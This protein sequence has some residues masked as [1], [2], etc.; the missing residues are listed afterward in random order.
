MST[1]SSARRA[2]FI[3]AAVLAALVRLVVLQ[4]SARAAGTQVLHLSARGH[5]VLRFNVNHLTA[6]P[7]RIELVMANP[8]D[9]GMSHGIAISGNGVDKDGK[10][11]SPG[12]ASTVTVT[13]RRR[14]Y[15]YYCPVPGHRAA[16]MKGTS[17]FAERHEATGT[18]GQPQAVADRAARAASQWS[19]SPGSVAA[20]VRAFRCRGRVSE[21]HE[22]RRS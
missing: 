4:A 6:H 19:A 1:A 13:L 7:G 21:S 20:A 17:P 11:V 22:V 18:A 8:G 12:R 10:I 5:M 16:G 15:T 2:G 14:S 9:A 3:G